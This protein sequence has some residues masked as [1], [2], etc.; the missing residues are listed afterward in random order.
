MA[1]G[2]VERLATVAE[3]KA[4]RRLGAKGEALVPAEI[5]WRVASSFVRR[6]WGTLNPFH[7]RWLGKITLTE[8]GRRA[9]ARLRQGDN[10]AD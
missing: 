8:A 5:S 9:L 10:D 6:G 3:T 2:D 7:E 4:A 1:S